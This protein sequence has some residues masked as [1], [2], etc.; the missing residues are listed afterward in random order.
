MRT[1]LAGFAILACWMGVVVV[2]TGLVKAWY[3]L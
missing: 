2:G 1:A 3:G